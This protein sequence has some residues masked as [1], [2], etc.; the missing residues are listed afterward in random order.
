MPIRAEGAT[1]GGAS[2]RKCLCHITQDSVA[3][4]MTVCAIHFLE[5]VKIS[6][7]IAYLL[8]VAQSRIKVTV[9]LTAVEYAG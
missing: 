2:G 1:T 4:L 6:K 7:D 3:D 5:L 8:C 9:K